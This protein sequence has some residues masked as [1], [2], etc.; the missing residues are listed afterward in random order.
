MSYYVITKSQNHED[1]R[2]VKN[3]FDKPEIK[4]QYFFKWYCDYKGVKADEHVK[5]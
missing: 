2:N 5:D 4:R 1:F 3:I